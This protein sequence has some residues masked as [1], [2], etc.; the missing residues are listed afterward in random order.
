ME[1]GV[2]DLLLSAKVKNSKITGVEVQEKVCELARKNV[3][4][5]NLEDR[6]EI[7]NA[8]IKDLNVKNEYDAVVTNPPYKANGTG[9]KNEMDTKIIARHETC[10][11]LEEFIKTASMSLK[12]KCAMYMV[13]RPERLIDICEYSRKYKLEPKEIRFVHSKI[14]TKPILVLIKAVKYANSFLKLKEPLYIYREDGEY[15]DEILKIYNKNR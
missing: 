15:S 4:F 13:N 9:L 11:T 12:D 14:Y 8:N 5:N 7:I 2:L 3:I 1:I 6:I 10:G